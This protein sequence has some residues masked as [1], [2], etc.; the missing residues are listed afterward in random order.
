MSTS[1]PF[2]TG[3]RVSGDDVWQ[4]KFSYSSFIDS[5]RDLQFPGPLLRISGRRRQHHVRDTG[6]TD[7]QFLVLW[8]ML[9]DGKD[10]HNWIP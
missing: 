6:E 10:V 8:H 5:F 9:F 3:M 2:A 7:P 4:I 1:I